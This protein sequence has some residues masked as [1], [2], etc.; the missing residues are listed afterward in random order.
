M[1]RFFFRILEVLLLLNFKEEFV[2]ETFGTIPC[3]FQILQFKIDFHGSF[4][5][6]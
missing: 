2:K 4:V 3:V 5:S 1:K 6:L